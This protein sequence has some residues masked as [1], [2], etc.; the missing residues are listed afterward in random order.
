V[1][2]S[3]QYL[4]QLRFPWIPKDMGSIH[5]AGDPTSFQSE[6]PVPLPHHT[7]WLSSRWSAV[8]RDTGGPPNQWQYCLPPRKPAL[9]HVTELFLP[10]KRDKLNSEATRPVNTRDYEIVRGKHKNLSNRS[11]SNLERGEPNSPT[12]TSSGYIPTWKARF[13]L[14]SYLMKMIEAFKEDIN[15]YKSTWAK[16]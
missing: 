11:Q 4:T 10:T 9:T 12:I 1:R 8:T 13:Y 5:S 7:V 2:P 16:R 14:K 3:P 6:T 15:K